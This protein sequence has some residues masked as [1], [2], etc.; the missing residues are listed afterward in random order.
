MNKK[1][2]TAIIVA[3][4]NS[5][6]F[7]QNKNKNLFNVN[8][9][10]IV[11]YSIE[12]FDKS[13]QIE[14]IILV[15]KETEREYFEAIVKNIEL[16]KPIKYVYGGKERKDSVYNALRETTS[17]I[18]IIHDGARPKVKL[19]YI[20]KCLEQME[21]FK[22]ATVAV[23]SKDTIKI[24]DDNGVVVETTKR[25]NTYLIQTP[26]C[27]DRKLLTELHEEFK[28][29]EGITDDCMILE[30]AGYKVKIVEGDYTN[31]KV[32]TFDDL[33]LVEK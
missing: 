2:V 16:H 8:E 4:G 1:T 13:K 30:K 22:G 5:T 32:T 25:A 7:G 21:E 18:V 20:D 10:P 31:I 6:R 33:Y 26:Q 3:A 28:E 15:I 11:R 27:F 23:K 29:E 24:C 19:E 17:D 14:D 9:K 12:I